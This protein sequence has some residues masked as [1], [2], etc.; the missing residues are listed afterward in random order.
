MFIPSPHGYTWQQRAEL[1]AR[2]RAGDSVREIAR[3]LAKDPG[4]LHGV[5]R[6]QGGIS[7]R[8]R[9]RSALAL[10]LDERERISRGLAAGE[11]YRAIGRALGRAAST[12]SRE[13]VRHG[14]PTKYRAV[15]A[16]AVAWKSARRPKACRLASRPRLRY[17]IATKLKRRWSLEQ[18]SAWLRRTYPHA[19]E[20]H[21]SHETI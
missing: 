11:S 21:V 3:D 14:G 19:P 18:I 16:D 13:V 15:R 5:I 12:I 6:K 1:W 9:A 8:L 17:L 2:Y 7:P 20:L 10:S 4:A